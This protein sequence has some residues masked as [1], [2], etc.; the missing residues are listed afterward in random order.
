MNDD[1]SATGCFG[2]TSPKGH[3]GNRAQTVPGKGLNALLRFYGPLE[4][5][6]DKSWKP[7]DFNLVQ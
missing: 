3:E 1:L 2:P 7:G 4:P 6:F 5:W